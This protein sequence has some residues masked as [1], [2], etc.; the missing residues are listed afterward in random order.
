MD[1]LTL[2]GLA[3]V[4]VYVNTLTRCRQ[5]DATKRRL[6]ER[7]VTF[8]VV[9]I[10][11]PELAETLAWFKERGFTSAPIVVLYNHDDTERDI[12]AGFRPDLVDE[13][14]PKVTE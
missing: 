10:D 8:D 14:F 12:W 3:K 11:S 2:S 7:G 9:A 6:T 5:C 13:H 4:T 1:A